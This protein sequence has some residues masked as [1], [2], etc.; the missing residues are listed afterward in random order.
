MNG[1]IGIP[2]WV[3]GAVIT[4]ALAGWGA[5]SGLSFQA[6]SALPRAEAYQVFV[7]QDAYEKD[8][9][10]L[11]EELKIISVDVRKTRESVI[12]MEGYLQ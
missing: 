7:T 5:F 8:I 1:R 10:A 9:V 12:R 11:R 4:V 3:I 6:K 2:K